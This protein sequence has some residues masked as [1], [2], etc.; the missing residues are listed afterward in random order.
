MAWH[1]NVHECLCRCLKRGQAEQPNH[2]DIKTCKPNLTLKEGKPLRK[3]QAKKASERVPGQESCSA[4]LLPFVKSVIAPNTHLN[5]WHNSCCDWNGVTSNGVPEVAGFQTECFTRCGKTTECF[6]RCGKTTECFTRC[7]KT[8]ECYTRCGKTTECY[9]RC[10]KTTECYTRCGK[11]TECYTRCGKT[12]RT[13]KMPGL[14]A[15]QT[16]GT[17]RL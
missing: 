12:T 5:A 14:H 8:T 2:L 17:H 16:A 11:T 13:N 15:L 3:I 10:G 1:V 9:T 4:Q 6:T 7:G